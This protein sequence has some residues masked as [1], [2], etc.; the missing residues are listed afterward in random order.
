[1][2]KIEEL[3]KEKLLAL[4]EHNT[5]K[6]NLL[7][8]IISNYQLTEIEKKAKGETM[9]DENMFSILNKVLKGLNEEKE[10]FAS[11]NKAEEA[12]N[13]EEQ[14]N[15]VKSYLPKLLSEEEIRKIISSLSNKSVK[16]IMTKFKTDYA[17]KVDFAIVAKVAKEFN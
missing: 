9:N 14:I 2:V 13:I 11:N 16:S 17:S 5:N 7:S 10:M 15:I 3:K 12:K 8:V 6:S 1:M 4:K